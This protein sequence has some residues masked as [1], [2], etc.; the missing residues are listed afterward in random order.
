MVYLS[1]G[2]ERVYVRPQ[3]DSLDD[4]VLELIR[5]V[6]RPV[7]L[8]FKAPPGAPPVTGNVHVDYTSDRDRQHRQ[9]ANWELLAIRNGEARCEVPVP[10]WFSY[11]INNRYGRD[12]RPV[13]YW[14]PEARSMRIAAGQDPCLIEVPVCPAGAIYGKILGP[15]GSVALTARENLFLV[16]REIL[17]QEPPKFL[18]HLFKGCSTCMMDYGEQRGTFKVTPLPLGG[19]YVV[20][21]WDGNRSAASRLIHLD[22]KHPVIEVNLQLL[23]GVTVT[24]QLVDA[25]GH[26]VRLPVTFFGEPAASLLN[27]GDCAGS[28]VDPDENGRFVFENVNPGPTGICGL[29]VW[30]RS[31]YQYVVLHRIKDLR[32]P[33]TIRLQ[34]GL[35]LHGTVIDDATGWPV[36]NVLLYAFS[37]PEGEDQTYE[38]TPLR[39]PPEGPTNQRGEFV[40]SNLSPG[41]YEVLCF[42][43]TFA[44]G[45]QTVPVT[46]G[47]SEPVTLRITIPKWRDLQ[48]RKPPSAQP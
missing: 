18:G 26:P 13:G 42:N 44:N 3:Q 43:A 16:N 5:P 4:V 41:R 22:E 14:F 48:P 20:V 24:G 36:P 27:D 28:Q 11:S 21:A 8:R 29:S 32:S 23:Q 10:G 15:G 40:F 33:V 39:L 31:N 17:K 35:R 1:A 47:Q 37:A 19:D 12:E 6:L 25:E 30:P 2:E 9:G 34:K 38:Q 7:V 46:A 45:Q